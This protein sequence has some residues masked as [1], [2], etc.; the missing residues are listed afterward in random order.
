MP[1]GHVRE[2]PPVRERGLWV[3]RNRSSLEGL[4]LAPCAW[5]QPRGCAGLQNGPGGACPWLSRPPGLLVVRCDERV[6]CDITSSCHTTFRNFFY[7]DTTSHDVRVTNDAS[8]LREVCHADLAATSPS[9]PLPAGLR[10]ACCLI[11]VDDA[12]KREANVSFSLEH[13][14]G[15]LRWV[16]QRPFRLG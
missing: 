1:A 8:F 4:S 13:T 14:T 7:I 9:R 15:Q 6:L 10:E 2:A 12:I 11:H 5:R 16:N 3:P